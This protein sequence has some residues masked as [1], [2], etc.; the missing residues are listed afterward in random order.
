MIPVVRVSDGILC[1]LALIMFDDTIDSPVLFTR[2]INFTIAVSNQ[3]VVINMIN[4]LI[5]TSQGLLL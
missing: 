5:K 4:I 3:S 1:P 2:L